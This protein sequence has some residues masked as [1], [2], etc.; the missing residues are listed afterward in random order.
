M[1]WVEEIKNGKKYRRY[2]IQLKFAE[3]KIKNSEPKQIIKKAVLNLL[4][5][6]AKINDQYFEETIELKNIIEQYY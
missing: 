6:L 5:N 1:A 4:H 3:N 2:S